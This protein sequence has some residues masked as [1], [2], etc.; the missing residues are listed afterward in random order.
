M[1]ERERDHEIIKLGKV[2]VALPEGWTVTKGT[3]YSLGVHLILGFPNGYG[4]SVV[5]N[6]YSY[7]GQDGLFELAVLGRDG[8]ITYDTEITDDVEGYLTEGEVT[9][10]LSKVSNL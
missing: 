9:E 5:R 7:G 2:D 8:H 3:N 10:L 4:A 6:P 1:P